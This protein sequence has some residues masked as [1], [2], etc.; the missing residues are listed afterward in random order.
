MTPT[1]SNTPQ[2]LYTDEYLE[3]E[4]HYHKWL[5][6]DGAD[7]FAGWDCITLLLT[8]RMRDDYEARLAAL[9]A[10]N[11]ELER[12]NKGLL[13]TNERNCKDAMR[14][15]QLGDAAM[16]V[17]RAGID[18]VKAKDERIAE[19]E[20]ELTDLRAQ[21]ARAQEWTPDHIYALNYVLGCAENYIDEY[22]P[23]HGEVMLGVVRAMSATLEANNAD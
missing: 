9:Q 14:I 3:G 19:L 6:S 13:D 15:D 5:L 1:P 8:K 22:K 17:V 21:L 18:A 4:K 2:P 10:R 7:T 11:D 23:E 16:V 12:I 20:Q